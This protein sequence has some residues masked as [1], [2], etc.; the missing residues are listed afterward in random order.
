MSPAKTAEPIEMPYGLVTQVGQEPCVR[1]GPDPQSG[2]GMGVILGGRNFGLKSEGDEA[3]FLT[4][5]TYKVGVHP[6]T[7]KSAI[8]TPTL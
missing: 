7:P 2:R 5:C 8:Q 4:W 1:W 3:K 6:S